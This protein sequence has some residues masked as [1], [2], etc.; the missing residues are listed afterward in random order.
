MGAR[1]GDSGETSDFAK[2]NAIFILN[3]C[4]HFELST[5]LLDSELSVNVECSFVL[6]MFIC[7]NTL[8]LI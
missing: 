3:V 2:T 7:Y 4:V 6:L 5:A 8:M 1:W